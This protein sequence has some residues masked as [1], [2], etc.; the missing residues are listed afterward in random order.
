MN[1]YER[2]GFQIH[3]S[4]FHDHEL[5]AMRNEATRLQ[6]KF[7]T[8]C[9]RG[10]REKSDLFRELA[11]DQRIQNLIPSGFTPIRS[12]L[13]DKTPDENWPVAWHQ[14]LTIAVEEKHEA[15]GYGPWSIKDGV[16]HVQP[17]I[18]FLEGMTTIRIHLDDTSAANGALRVIP[19]SHTLGRLSAQQIQAQA[20]TAEVTCECRAGDILQMS[21][22][23][24]HAS[25]RSKNP[26]RRRII[27]F[28]FGSPKDLHPD[29]QF[30]EF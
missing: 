13:F 8:A 18:S 5:D 1:R 7:G 4:V 21:P 12:I 16:P 14:D 26:T 19:G 2:D 23:I 20:S 30:H 3:S 9:L 27:H 11:N 25:S 15:D 24:L 6:E 10:L 29:L 17:P 28:E 22:L